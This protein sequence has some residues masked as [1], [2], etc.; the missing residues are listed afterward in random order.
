MLREEL[1]NVL[2]PSPPQ[3]ATDT[4]TTTATTATA[5]AA[6]TTTAIYQPVLSLL[7]SLWPIADRNRDWQSMD[8]GVRLI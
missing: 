1:L 3:S 6:A 4:A 8:D 7:V 2:P 5:A